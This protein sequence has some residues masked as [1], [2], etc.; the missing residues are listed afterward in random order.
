MSSYKCSAWPVLAV[1][2]MVVFAAPPIAAQQS[3]SRT[4]R[5]VYEE[6]CIT[7]HGPD[8]RAGVNAEIEKIVKPPDF[9][10]CAFAA[11]EPD[12][13]FL[14]VAH[15]GG[16]ARGF[17][18]LMAPLGGVYT[19]EELQ[20]AIS[21]IRTFCVDQRWPR[22]ELNLPRPLVTAKAFP[23][24]E[25]VVS[26]AGQ[27]GNITTKVHYEKRFGPLNMVEVILPMTSREGASGDQFAGVGDIA[28]EYKR[29][30]AH[31][32]DRGNIFSLTGELVLPTG[33]ERRGLGK[34]YGVFEPFATFGQLL[35]HD[36]FLQMQSGFAI[37]LE[38]G[39]D[40]E[41]FWRAAVGKSF[42]QTKFGRVWSP[43]LEILMARP[44][45]D[46]AKTS[47]DLLPGMQ[48]T[49]NARQHVRLAG[50]VRLPVTDADVR[51]KSVIVYLLW[52]WYEGGFLQGW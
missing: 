26:T 43:M 16:T 41:F 8:G 30:L 46:H 32:L 17:S 33:S 2:A 7:C 27:S 22:G 18:P 4:G 13:G 51:K 21:H 48:V 52:D 3:S 9:T 20:L 14:A 38:G 15:N 40:D 47:W 35:P 31:S 6:V 19:E 44:L 25:M 42:E 1:A 49:L 23:E 11:R 39:H 24:D 29:T 5:Q 37:P 34:G 45:A 28:L 50:G 10:D 36:S 12:R